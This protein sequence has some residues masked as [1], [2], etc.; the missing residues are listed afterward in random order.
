MFLSKKSTF[1]EKMQRFT[2]VSSGVIRGGGRLVGHG[3]PLANYIHVFFV[4]TLHGSM[5]T[6]LALLGL[7]EMIDTPLPVGEV[8]ACPHT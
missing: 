3:T 5:V 2:A 8:G 6:R 1:P 4:A 7:C